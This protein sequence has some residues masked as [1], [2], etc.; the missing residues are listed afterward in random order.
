MAEQGPAEPAAGP[1]KQPSAQE[2]F[3]RAVAAQETRKLK[4]GRTGGHTWR[5]LGMLGLVG[6]SVSVPTLLGTFIGLWLDSRHPG[7][8]SWT[9]ALLF[10][11]LCLGCASSWHWISQEQ[12]AIQ[13]QEKE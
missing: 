11:G 2:Q 3:S 4:A 8:R 10:A 6:W 13:K 1:A 5:G 9:V 12:R 7:T